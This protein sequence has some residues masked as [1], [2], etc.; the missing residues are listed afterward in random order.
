M[1]RTPLALLLA[2]ALLPGCLITGSI[3]PTG[4]ARL[5]INVRLIS[6][7]NFDSMKAALQ[8]SDVVLK[9]ASMT[10]KKFATFEIECADVTKLSTA[11]SLSRAI[12]A[13]T[14]VG[15]GARTF[16]ASL[17]NPAPVEWS[18]TMQHY[19]GDELKIAVDLP[20]DVVATNAPAKTGRTVTWSWPLSEASKIPRLD[21][22]ATYN[23]PTPAS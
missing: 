22:F 17:F 7:A 20:A 1:L 15:G 2:L 4:G 23:R 13:L 10:P 9:N 11:P 19:Y 18:P 16:A 21:L 3:D 14:D 8:S 5:T 12:I 6:V